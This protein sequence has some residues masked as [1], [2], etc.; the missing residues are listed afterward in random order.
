MMVVLGYSP[1]DQQL[2]I[3]EGPAIYTYAGVTPFQ[4]KRVKLL[5]HKA[6][7]KAWQELR[8]YE[9]IARKIVTPDNPEIV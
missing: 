1:Q 4:H 5:V 2:K 8:K 3:A 9:L 7:G 6:Q